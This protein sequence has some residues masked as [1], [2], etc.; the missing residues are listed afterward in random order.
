MSLLVRH[1]PLSLL[2]MFLLI[3]F[4]LPRVSD[5]RQVSECERKRIGEQPIDHQ[6]IS[7]QYRRQ[8]ERG[9]GADPRP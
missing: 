7:Y 3:S 5:R 8:L 4:L 2:Y 6:W 1:F 9:Y